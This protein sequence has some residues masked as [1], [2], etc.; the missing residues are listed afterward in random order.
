MGGEAFKGPDGEPLATGIKQAEVGPTLDA[1]LRDVL[2]P[3]GIDSY[4]PLGSTG[5]KPISGDLDIAVGPVP[6][7]DPK[8]LKALKDALLANI[9]A[10]VGPDNAK[11]VG[12]NIAILQ[13]IAGSPDRFVQV[14]LMLSGDPQKTGW[15]MSGTGSGVKGVYRNLMLAY[16]A[17]LRSEEQTG[18][19][20]TIS[21]PGGIQVVKDGQ[22]V[23]PRTED[24]EAIVST[25]G[26]PARPSEI[27][28]FEELVTILAR[29]PSISGKLE[30]YET[31]I[32]RYLQDPKTA[33][34]AQKSVAALKTA[35]GLMETVRLLIRSLR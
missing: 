32:G 22:T 26:I 14:D 31:Y 3:V 23:V 28:T 19:K 21:Y 6:M 5:K 27:N 30:G 7:N 12:Q 13:P 16:I 25:L 1:L 18:T 29:D 35:R 34:E 20:I 4:V 10:V 17:K 33:V 9:Q 24:A 15:L 11:L 2:R 8:A